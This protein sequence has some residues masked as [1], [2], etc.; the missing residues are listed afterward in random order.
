MNDRNDNGFTLVELLVVIAI[1]ALLVAILMPTLQQ[2]KEMARQA[3]CQGNV[4][5]VAMAFLLY[6]EDHEEYM[7]PNAVRFDTLTWNGQTRT[8]VWVPWYSALYL[9]PYINNRRIGSSA[10][11]V[12]Q[13]G[14]D[15]EII[16]CPSRED[17]STPMR[18]GIGYNNVWNCKFFVDKG[19]PTPISGFEWPWRTLMLIDVPRG[20]TFQYIDQRAGSESIPIYRHMGGWCNVSF[21]DAH[22][23]AYTDLEEAEDHGEVTPKAW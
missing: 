6:A 22:A 3:I 17:R 16:Y 19:G 1:I 2:A 14:S 18:V 9:G 5:H 20:H 15:S 7:A 4:R 10:F 12:K 23:G 13:Q 8:N 21:A 11:S